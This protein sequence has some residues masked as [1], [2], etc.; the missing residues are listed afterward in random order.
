MQHS[1]NLRLSY[2]VAIVRN[3]RTLKPPVPYLT[4]HRFQLIHF[5]IIKYSDHCTQPSTI[6][7]LM[8]IKQTTLKLIK[9]I[10]HLSTQ[11][12]PLSLLGHNLL[13]ICVQAQALRLLVRCMQTV[14]STVYYMAT[15]R[16]LKTIKNNKRAQMK[17]I[18]SVLCKLLQC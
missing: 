10:L 2:T 14:T 13:R 12:Y 5:Q 4:T 7:L 8:L 17:L 3:G 9:L 18:F 11:S 16:P 1:H 15:T 6:N